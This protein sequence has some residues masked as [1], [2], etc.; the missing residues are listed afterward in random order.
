MPAFSF[1]GPA[2]GDVRAMKTKTPKPRRVVPR[3]DAAVAA[4]RT[5]GG[6]SS[7]Q[8][9]RGRR[10]APYVRRRPNP[11]GVGRR[12]GRGAHTLAAWPPCTHHC[13][14]LPLQDCWPPPQRSTSSHG[15]RPAPDA[16]TGVLPCGAAV[17]ASMYLPPVRHSRR[18]AITPSPSPSNLASWLD[19]SSR[20]L[21]TK[22]A[23]RSWIFVPPALDGVLNKGHRSLLLSRLDANAS[24]RR[25]HDTHQRTSNCPAGRERGTFSVGCWDREPSPRRRRRG[26]DRFLGSFAGHTKCQSNAQNVL[27]VFSHG[28]N[29]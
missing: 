1:R 6:G 9:R 14:L 22:D 18:V 25:H 10:P 15:R 17:P 19:K 27:Q 21:T 24:A 12:A 8:A 7:Q 5:R 11:S 16:V 4:E 3:H 23:P 29:E 20:T 2:A 26:D 28:M 13:W